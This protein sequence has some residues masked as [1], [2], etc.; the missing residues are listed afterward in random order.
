MI[1]KIFKETYVT[2]RVELTQAD[3]NRLVQMAQMKAKK[4]EERAREIYEKEGVTKIQFTG[5][6][7]RKR[8]N[9]VESD[10]YEFTVDCN[11]YHITPTGEYEKTLYKIPQESRQKIAKCVK[12][13]VE[14]AFVCYFGEHMV[15]LN[16]IERLKHKQQRMKDKFVIVTIVGW[17]LAVVMCVAIFHVVVK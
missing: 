5:R 8:Y 1:E 9:E 13:F 10:R 7:Y 14:E 4:I 2:P 6:F 12:N 3:Y 11:D 16:E 15:N 17:L